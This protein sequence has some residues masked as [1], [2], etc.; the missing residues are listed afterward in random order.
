MS[1]KLLIPISLLA[2]AIMTSI[3]LLS[4]CDPMDIK[5]PEPG[6]VSPWVTWAITPSDSVVHYYNPTLQ[7]FGGD[8]DGQINDFIYGV[9]Q[10]AY[11]DS[12][13][14]VT[15]LEI[16]D[17][18][19]WVSVGT[20]TSSRVPLVASPDSSVSVGQYV[21][22]RAVDD[23]GDY[24]ETI[25]R[26]LMRRNNRPT[27]L[28]TVPEGPQWVLPETTSTW[29][30]IDISWEGGDSLDYTGAQPDFLWEVRIF[31]P[32][33]AVPDTLNPDTSGAMFLRYLKDSD[34][35]SLRIEATSASL[36]DLR[37][38]YYIISV[39]N[40]DDANV[41]SV[42][43][44]GVI[45]VYEPHWIYHPDEAKDILFLNQN[46]FNPLP[47]NLPA[48][49]AD[50]V[51]QFYSDLIA[52]AGIAADKWDW[53][54][55]VPDINSLYMY[56]LVLISD[57]D[58]NADI[59]T[60]VQE[61]IIDYMN[62]GGKLW[63]T[64]R[65]SFYN[66]STSAGLYE[67]LGNAAEPLPFTY[68]GLEAAYYPPYNLTD[69]EFVGAR[70]NESANAGLPDLN[71]DT[72]KIQA[73]NGSFDYALPRV[74]RLI[75][76]ADAQTVYTFNAIL[77]NAPN[78]FHGFPVGVR[79]EG[80]TFKSSYF[81]FPLFFIEYSQASESFNVMLDWFLEE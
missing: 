74:E 48:G 43:A 9:F 13:T 30:G 39:R 25:N 62:V 52:D 38:G 41:P 73:L 4:G 50:S 63:V 35:D 70:E 27:C 78:T 66:T 10:A 54:D 45:D 68:L 81:C 29:N 57:L 71:V 60:N 67:Y 47:A 76:T 51:H 65:F 36:V 23:Q 17:T 34:D 59:S 24:S 8:E 14:R 15:S 44:L 5:G 56:R 7:W 58:W 11:M 46:S 80:P 19:T 42:P 53:F 61:P 12:A 31:G 49:W 79:M 21:V 3:I 20:N 37:T 26:Y 32:Y 40:F 6:N 33:A 1:R 69:A 75:I 18:L 2:A 55:A 72:L 28:V 16:P 77:P 22:L 64:G